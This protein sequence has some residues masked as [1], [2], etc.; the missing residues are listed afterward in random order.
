S[1]S[2]DPSV[3]ANVP[4][5]SDAARLATDGWSGSVGAPDM[6]THPSDAASPSKPGFDGKNAV[7]FMADGW[8]PAGKALAITVL[9]YDNASGK[10]L[11]ADVIVNGSYS[12]AVLDAQNPMK[13][14]TTSGDIKAKNTDGITHVDEPAG[15]DVIYDLYHVVAH[16][17]G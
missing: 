9:T 4:H 14:V 3:D 5:G 2:I 12:F 6:H 1:Y 11:D 13:Q 15:D 16:E 10:I 17:F 7:F 8:A